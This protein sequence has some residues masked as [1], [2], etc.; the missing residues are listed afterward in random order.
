M[1]IFKLNINFFM[2][3]YFL[4]FDQRD[5]SKFLVFFVNLKVILSY[6]FNNPFNF[7]YKRNYNSIFFY[8]HI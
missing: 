6:F 7:M 3:F 2:I 8:F 4:Y 5:C 1:K